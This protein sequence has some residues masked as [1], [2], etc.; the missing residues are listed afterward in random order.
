MHLSAKFLIT[1]AVLSTAACA[2][3]I[4][5]PEH[6]ADPYEDINRKIFAFNDSAYENVFFPII[7]GYRKITTPTIR[8]RIS[9]FTS[10]MDEPISTVNY[11]LQLKPVETIKSAARFVINSTLGL[12]GLFDVATGWGLGQEDATFNQTFA[13]WCIADGPYL[14]VP[15]LGSSS[16]RD[17]VGTTAEVIADPI[18]WTLRNDSSVYY[19]LAYP[20]TAVKYANKFEGYIDLYEDFKKNSVDLYATMRS[21]YLQRQ[22]KYRC[23]FA[24]PETEAVYDFD[25]DEEFED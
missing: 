12:A 16:P 20:Y 3:N 2:T 22:S 19:K 7:R 8:Q 6:Q 24:A 21:A 17:L 13:S 15:L 18:Y 4:H 5:R 10:N 9:N 11:M 1:A 25:F 14:V 23:R